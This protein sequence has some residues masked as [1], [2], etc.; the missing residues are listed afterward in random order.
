MDAAAR[1]MESGARA[2]ELLQKLRNTPPERLE[3]ENTHRLLKEAVCCRLMTDPADAEDTDDL[4]N[5]AVLSIR[6]QDERKR[7]LA[8]SAIRNQ[9]EKYDC[10][11]TNLVAQKKVLLMMYVE[12]MLGISLEDEEA[13]GILTVRDF[14]EAVRKKLGGKS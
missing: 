8:D 5:L 3:P 1:I 2:A 4:R 7:G 11:Q 10:H 9:I 13:A 12:K 6:R 14:S